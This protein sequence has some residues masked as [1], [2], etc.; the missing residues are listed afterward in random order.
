MGSASGYA[1]WEP[2]DGS[3][4]ARTGWQRAGE[5]AGPALSSTDPPTAVV[6]GNN[7]ATI[8]LMKACRQLG[9]SIPEDLALAAFDDFEWADAST[10]D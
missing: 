7:Q 4:L 10:R 5:P 1:G 2:G 9:V 6:T 3:D 8:E